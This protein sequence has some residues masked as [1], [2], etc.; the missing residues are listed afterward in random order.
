M[1]SSIDTAELR[2]GDVFLTRHNAKIASIRDG[3]KDLILQP[4]E[5]FKVPFTPMNFDES[6]PTTRLNLFLHPCRSLLED[7]ASIDEWLIGYLADHSVEILKKQMNFE[8]VRESYISCIRHSAKGYA[9]TVKTKIDFTDGKHAL[10]CWDAD[11]NLVDAPENWKE[12]RI[13]PRIHVSHVWFIGTNFGPVLR[14]TDA[15]LRP[16]ADTPAS[17]KRKSPL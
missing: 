6:G 5:F 11:G 8:E 12:F 15:L 3:S 9:P 13:S 1:A 16:E 4:E 14:L 17:V 2:L 7:V 10:H